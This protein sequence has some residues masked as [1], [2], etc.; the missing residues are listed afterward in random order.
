MLRLT[1][2]CGY[3]VLLSSVGSGQ[4]KTLKA[5]KINSPSFPQGGMIPEKFTCDGENVSPA[6]D[7]SEI[8]AGTKSFALICDDPDAPSGMWVHWVVYNIPHSITLFDEHFVYMNRIV[9]DIL[10]GTNDFRRQEYGGPCPPSGTHRYYFKIYALD[11]ILKEKEGLTKSQL[12]KAMEGH[13]IGK[14]EMMGRYAR[15]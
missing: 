12:E 4:H 13:V 11:C 14:G 2:I 1:L 15:R 7:W 3:C 10:A 6:L 9:K 5:M 8:P